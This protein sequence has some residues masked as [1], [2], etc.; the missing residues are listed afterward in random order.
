MSTIFTAFG[1]HAKGA[2]ML[3]RGLKRV[4]LASLVA[5]LLLCTAL[6]ASAEIT[7]SGADVTVVEFSG[8]T[9]RQEP[10]GTWAELDANGTITATFFEVSRDEQRVLLVDEG[11]G[12]SVTLDL[13]ER[14]ITFGPI[15]GEQQPLHEIVS[16]TAEPPTPAISVSAEAAA[17][18]ATS[19][20]ATSVVFG[21][22]GEAAGE[23]RMVGA[24]DWV[25]LDGAGQPAFEFKE[26]D[27][28]A[29]GIKLVDESRG[30]ALTLDVA[31]KIITYGAIGDEQQPL[32]E[33]ISA[34]AEAA[35]EPAADVAAAPA[36]PV[37]PEPDETGHIA[38]AVPG[39]DYS[40]VKL[41][42]AGWYVGRFRVTWSETDA[43]GQATTGSW[44]SGD[45]QAPFFHVVEFP[46]GASA[47]NVVGEGEVEGQWTEALNVTLAGPT[48]K[49][50]KIAGTPLVQQSDESDDPS[51]GLDDDCP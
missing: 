36:E 5:G 40:F 46:D 10:D 25:E 15:N 47:I 30:I 27:R 4:G 23:Y 42:H 7:V 43:A 14:V 3:R 50:Y 1:R 9:Y 39:L 37:A 19:E 12:L 38:P 6:P 22:N 13:A 11:R 33:I 21:S 18:A 49:C 35:A 51:S 28:G 29:T 34:T 48:N 44:E 16:A 45:Q 32:Y 24:G 41:K 2:P 31:S 26:T 17:D 20:T 8:G